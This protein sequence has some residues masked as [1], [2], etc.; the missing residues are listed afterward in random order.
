MGV[1]LRRCILGTFGGLPHVARAERWSHSLPDCLPVLI[2][3]P[4]QHVFAS[5]ELQHMFHRLSFYNESPLCRSQSGQ[6][7]EQLWYQIALTMPFHDA[8]SGEG[9][10]GSRKE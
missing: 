2:C 10:A 4:R 8:G 3:V 9:L 1:Q 5:Q 6:L 7:Q